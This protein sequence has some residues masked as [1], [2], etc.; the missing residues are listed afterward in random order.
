M[1]AAERLREVVKDLPEETAREVLDFTEFLLARL[2]DDEWHEFT[3]R[4]F[5]KG[6]GDNEPEY[7]LDDV[8]GR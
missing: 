1:T 7:T 3:R 5:A 6:F 8:I 2:E 4:G